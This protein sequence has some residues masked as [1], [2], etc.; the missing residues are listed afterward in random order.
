MHT[1][2]DGL[3]SRNQGLERVPVL[4][5]ACAGACASMEESSSRSHARRFL[6]YLCEKPQNVRLV[7]SCSLCDLYGR[8]HTPWYK[9]F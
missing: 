7:I 9:Y 3:V 4:L 1:T 8:I 6:S 2:A 5:C